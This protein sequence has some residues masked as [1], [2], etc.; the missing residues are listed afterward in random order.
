[1]YSPKGEHLILG[2]DFLYH[3]NPI[4]DCK[5]GLI[6]Y[7]CSHKD[8]SS[9]KPSASN[10]LA[11]SVNSVALVGELKTPSLPSSAHIPSIMPSQSLVKLRDEVFKEIKDVGEDVSI[12]LL[13]LFQGDMDLSALSFHA[14]LE[15]QWA[16]EEEPEK[17]ETVLKNYSKKITDLTSLLKK[18]SPFIFNEGA[19]SQFQILKEAFTTAPIL[20]HFNPSLPTIVETDAS[21]YSLGAVLSQV[22]DSGKNPIEFDSHK[23]LQAELNYE[24]YD[25]ELL[26]IVWALEGWRAFLLSL[27]NPFEVLTDHSSLQ[28]FITSKVLTHHQARWAEFFSEFHFTITYRPGRLATLPDALSYRENLHQERGVDCISKNTQN[29]HQVI[30]K[31]GIQESRFFSIKLEI[32]SDLVDKIQKEVWKDKDY[33]EILK[34][35]ARGESVTEYSLEAQTKLLLFNDRVQ[36]TLK[37]IKR[38]FHRAGMNQVIKDYVSSFQKCS[39]NKNIHHKKFGLLKPL[40]IPSGP[41][42]SLSMEFITQL[43]LSNSFDSVVV[44]MNRLSK[45]EIFIPAYGTITDLELAHIFISHVFSKHGLPVSIVSDRGSL[46]VSSFWTNLCQ[47]L[48]ISRDLSTA[49][50]PEIDEQ[51]ERIN[52]ILEQNPSFDSIH[53][54]QDSPAG[55]LSTKLQ[56]VQKVV[57]E[58]LESEI[59]RFQK[60]EYS[61]RSI[62]PDF[63]PGNK[64]WL[65]S[66]KTK[67][68]RPTKRL[69]ERWLGPFEVLK[70]IGSHAYHLNFPFQWKSVHPVFHVS[71]LEPV[72]QSSIPNCNQSLPPP[73]LVEEQE[74]C[75]VAQVLDSKLKR[76]GLWYLLEWKGSSKDPERKT[77]EPASNLTSS[78]DLVKYFHSLYPDEPIPITSRV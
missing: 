57:K 12:S 64:V 65:A 24:I 23:L 43:P 26:G 69:S 25:K 40:Q 59:R 46:F 13:H 55:K 8:S 66:K 39:R 70:K 36:K 45:M 30:K 77:W 29:F 14:S 67:T 52:Q 68:T 28:Y 22:D 37:L 4:I 11:T 73:D 71:L 5:N 44:F 76:G 18:V 20:S 51:T 54:S 34:K 19:L 48:R 47:K 56:S 50:H 3:F 31:D 62:P 2:Y 58:E 41:W 15:E 74:E 6:T 75:K 32:F 42:N 7:D 60:F 49:F 17:I 38:D 1:M 53:I 78:P 16:E 9:I 21:D 10:A 61:N 72:K 63:Q 33:K 27:S 35:L